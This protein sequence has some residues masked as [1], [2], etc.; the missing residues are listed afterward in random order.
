MNTEKKFAKNYVYNVLYQILILII[1]LIT[2]PYVSRILGA[3]GIGIYNYA[4]S[5]ASYFVLFGAV[6]T[7]IYGQREIA[8]VQN[9]AQ[10][11]SEV[12]WQIEILRLFMTGLCLAGYY[13]F[14][15]VYGKYSFVFE[16][17][18]IEVLASAFDISWLYMGME[19][20]RTIVL[21]NSIVKA[22]GAVCIFLFVKKSADIAIYT[23][24]V[25]FPIL[26]GNVTLWIGLKKYVVSVPWE[27]E[28]IV[29]GIKQQIRP[30]IALF[31]PQVA[32]EI[33]VV[34]DKTMLGLLVSDI[35][36]VGYYSQAQKIVK[37]ILTI[38]TSLGTVML[39]AMSVAFAQGRTEKI[40]DSI[41]LALQ[42]VL[43]LSSALMF[44]LCAISDKFVPLFYGV[45]YLDVINL[46]AVISPIMIIIGISNVIGKQY[47]L[48]TNQQGYFTISIIAGA[49]TNFLLNLLLIPKYQA[50]GAS[51]AT[52]LAELTVTLI[53]CFIVTHQFSILNALLSAIKYLFF[54]VIMFICVKM[55]GVF[56]PTNWESIGIMIMI[57]CVV[58]ILELV[59]SK[60]KLLIVALKLF[61]HS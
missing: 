47:F 27:L 14:Y 42:F 21:R 44:G 26:I 35:K 57:G 30:I 33:Y 7:T 13:L 29:K 20:F 53:Q 58:F 46:I 17:L 24:C 40:K 32:M 60:D 1:P 45:G 41:R 2:T 10:K 16:I 39:P 4:E 5:I 50:M 52:V 36:Q 49:V 18:I 48:P 8:Y 43:M 31:I 25:V 59:V 28:S 22:A 34:L 37:I 38:V 55:A 19:N 51:V 11:R 56:L 6:G 9:D 61:R 23:G 12:F 54:G 15:T 3:S